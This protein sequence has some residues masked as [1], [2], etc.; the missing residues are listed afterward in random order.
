MGV[1]SSDREPL[2]IFIHGTLIVLFFDLF[3]YFLVFFPFPSLPGNFSAEA[4]VERVK[5]QK[6][7]RALKFKTN[8]NLRCR[9]DC[10]IRILIVKC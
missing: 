9:N 7:L 10:I 4:L 3:C 2:W 5:L 8:K 1:G 6:F